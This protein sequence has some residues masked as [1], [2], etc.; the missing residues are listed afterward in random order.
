MCARI[1][2]RDFS[3][4]TAARAVSGSIYA[5]SRSRTVSMLPDDLW[6]VANSLGLPSFADL[7]SILW[8]IAYG[9]GWSFCSGFKLLNY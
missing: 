3:S 9:S 6:I 1:V 2:P 5:P 4:R 8:F 7:F